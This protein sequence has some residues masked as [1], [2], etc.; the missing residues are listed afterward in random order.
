M[1]RNDLHIVPYIRSKC[2][3]VV[4]QNGHLMLATR[5]GPDFTIPKLN[6]DRVETL[7]FF[8]TVVYL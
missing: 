6:M 2:H 1:V 5:H 8:D 7:A 4:E 3:V